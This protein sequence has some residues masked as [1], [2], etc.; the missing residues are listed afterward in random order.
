M[1]EP[2]IERGEPGR[3]LKTVSLSY[4]VLALAGNVIPAGVP[5]DMTCGTDVTSR[6]SSPHSPG[7]PAAYS[8]QDRL[9]DI[10]H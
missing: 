3:I 7:T 8:R 1:L 2:R 6:H 4:G 5:C 9:E 10:E